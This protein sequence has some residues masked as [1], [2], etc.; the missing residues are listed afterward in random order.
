MYC[1][2]CA[3]PADKG[4]KYCR[5]CGQDLHMVAQAIKGQSVIKA[6]NHSMALWGMTLFIGGTALGSI[7][8][9]LNKEGIHIAGAMT[10]YLLALLL[11]LI[12]SGLGMLIYAFLP[13]MQVQRLSRSTERPAPRANTQPD[14]LAEVPATIT[15]HTTELLEEES[16]LRNPVAS[17]QQ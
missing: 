14:L 5:Q 4:Q 17:R 3:T 10:P 9:V 1:P 12:F 6:W 15:E 16:R 8:K 2:N 7:I 13:A 11:L